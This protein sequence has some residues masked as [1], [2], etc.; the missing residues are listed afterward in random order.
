MVK[1]ATAPSRARDVNIR[2][3]E[4]AFIRALRALQKPD[5]GALVSPLAPL[6]PRIQRDLIERIRRTRTHLVG[7]AIRD[8]VASGTYDELMEAAAALST[9]ARSIVAG[10]VDPALRQVLDET[11]ELA[12]ALLVASRRRAKASR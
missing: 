12:R 1:R 8:G 11:Q 3:L 6:R 7:A 4:L 2:S 5:V 10:R 9:A